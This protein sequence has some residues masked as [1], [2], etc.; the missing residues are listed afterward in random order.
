[1]EKIENINIDVVCGRSP[2]P[3]SDYNELPDL[4]E[5][6]HE[7]PISIKLV[8]INIPSNDLLCVSKSVAFFP[9][10]CANTPIGIKSKTF[11]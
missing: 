4:R 8:K 7:M 2:P 1:M 11:K 5:N 3:H 10:L 9:T 6:F